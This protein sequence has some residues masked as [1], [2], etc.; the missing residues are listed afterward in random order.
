MTTPL[1]RTDNTQGYSLDELDELNAEWDE[2]ARELGI[3]P[4]SDD[5]QHEAKAFCN[6]VSKRPNTAS[7]APPV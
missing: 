7:H 6:G 2:R 4:D 5:Y 3:T 1:F